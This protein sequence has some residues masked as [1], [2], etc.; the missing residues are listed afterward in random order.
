MNL[1]N[2][3]AIRIADVKN[4]TPAHYGTT[5]VLTISFCALIGTLAVAA[6]ALIALPSWQH[7]HA[8]AIR[9]GSNDTQTLMP[10]RAIPSAVRRQTIAWKSR[11]A[12][13][14]IRDPG[15]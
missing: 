7:I 4:W 2:V 12:G 13:V 11:H 6:L 15:R 9:T 1:R 8:Q 5:L 10:Q 14:V 3:S